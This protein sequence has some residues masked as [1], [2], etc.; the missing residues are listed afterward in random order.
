[1]GKGAQQHAL[2]N[3][4]NKGV[5][6]TTRAKAKSMCTPPNAPRDPTTLEVAVAPTDCAACGK[7][8]SSRCSRCRLWYCSSECQKGHW[9]VHKD[10]C[11]KI[12]KIGGWE[13]CHADAD[14]KLET[15]NVMRR[16]GCDE[17]F[18]GIC[19]GAASTQRIVIGGC[20][21]ASGAHLACLSRS[22]REYQQKTGK[23]V[24]W[25]RCLTCDEP[26]ASDVALSLAKCQW[27]GARDLPDTCWDKLRALSVLGNALSAAGRLDDALRVHTADLALCNANFPKDT[28]AL[29]EATHNLAAVHGLRGD[30]QKAIHLEEALFT[31]VTLE[32]GM[33]HPRTLRRALCLATARARA[34]DPRSELGL[35]KR[36]YAR[37]L[38]ALGPAH[39]VTV[40][41]AHAR[42]TALM[43]CPADDSKTLGLK[44]FAEVLLED[45]HAHA[46]AATRREIAADLSK[47][48]AWLTP[49]R[50][51]SRA[52]FSSMRLLPPA[53][54]VH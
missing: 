3:I 45:A 13:A 9:A 35:L 6:V 42:A 43:A 39:G 41:L 22:A 31:Q 19:G 36:S 29:Q 1:M 53:A 46:E 14:A 15:T 24:G 27:R 47:L 34:G 10:Q 51:A 54:V 8:G 52:V 49:R 11:K 7:E 28:D 30:H 18:C 25:H 38:K 33:D 12:A 17:G 44:L 16:R 4:E 26:H 32:R 21:C 23:V 2:S 48:R 50:E 37:A 20:G 40:D 5:L